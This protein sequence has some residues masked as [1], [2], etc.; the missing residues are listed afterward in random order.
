MNTTPNARELGQKIYDIFMVLLNNS[1]SMYTIEKE[2][3]KFLGY[4]VH[5]IVNIYYDKKQRHCDLDI[6]G[7]YDDEINVTSQVLKSDMDRY[8]FENAVN[9]W[10][11]ILL[12]NE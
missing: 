8:D 2:D 5:F 4:D 11:Q 3:F 6:K 9:T 10:V 7:V 12:Y 1:Q